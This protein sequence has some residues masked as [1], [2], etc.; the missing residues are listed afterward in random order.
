MLCGGRAGQVTTNANVTLTSCVNNGAVTTNNGYAGGIVSAYQQGS[1]T[2]TNCVNNG[3]LTGAYEGNM[4]GWYT[5]VSSITISSATNVFD[6]N[7]IGKIEAGW[8]VTQ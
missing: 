1:L 5:S 3:E 4:L 6:I 7:A 2:I 8:T